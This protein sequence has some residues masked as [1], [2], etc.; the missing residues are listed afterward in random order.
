MSANATK[1][2]PENTPR[3]N[4]NSARQKKQKLQRLAYVQKTF[5]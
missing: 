4:E 5:H 3:L 1:Q 2:T